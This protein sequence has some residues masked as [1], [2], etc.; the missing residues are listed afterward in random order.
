MELNGAILGLSAHCPSSLAEC[1]MYSL[2]KLASKEGRDS[3]NR[4]VPV[5]LPSFINQKSPPSPGEKVK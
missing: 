1:C 4:T 5:I 3:L 2:G